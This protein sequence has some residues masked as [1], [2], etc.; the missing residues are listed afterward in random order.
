[1]A[2][3]VA[4]AAPAQAAQGFVSAVAHRVGDVLCYRRLPWREPPAPNWLD[5]LFEDE[6]MVGVRWRCRQHAWRQ[7][8]QLLMFTLYIAPQVA[9]S[10]P[11]GLQASRVG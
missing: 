10:K 2:L 3:A 5:V 11:S 7:H 4:Q 6:H 1:M 9:L 8:G